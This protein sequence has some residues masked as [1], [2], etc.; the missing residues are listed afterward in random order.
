MLW[1]L[2][3]GVFI[4]KWINGIKIQGYSLL[5]ALGGFLHSRINSKDGKSRKQLGLNHG[6]S[7]IPYTE[8]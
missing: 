7:A 8:V 6:V 4:G 2:R 3:K 5:I 1:R